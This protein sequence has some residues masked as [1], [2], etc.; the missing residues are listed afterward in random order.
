MKAVRRRVRTTLIGSLPLLLLAACGTH[1][2]P[3]SEEAK[4]SVRAELATAERVEIPRRVEVH[5]IVEAEKTA[6]ISSRVS[7]MITRVLVKPGDA[8]SRGQVLIRID[9]QTADGQLAQA[10]GAL[11]QAQAA[12][13]LAERNFERFT[14]LAATDAASELEVDQARMQHEQALGAVEQA[15]GAIQ[16][17]QSVAAESRV[18]APFSGRIVRKM[19][20]VGDLAAPG[21]P[22]L[23]LESEGPRLLVLSVPESLMN[24]AAL[25]IGDL[26]PIRF[27]ARP[28]LGL[29]EAEVVEMTPAAD[30]VSHSFDIKLSLSDVDIAS[31]SSGRGWIPTAVREAVLA[32]TRALLQVGG[33]TLVVAKTTED[34]TSSRVVTLGESVDDERIEVLS[35]LA[36]GEVLLL[37]LK[38]VPPNGSPVEEGS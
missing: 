27:D 23:L 12:L 18:T 19:V 5:G 34:V 28:E 32:P 35:G 38:A 37:D 15:R 3:A 20:D 24:E 26:L 16:A 8:V 10:R 9:P 25:A 1:T 6:A 11:A 2:T 22:L 7:A 14:A 36:G 21:R 4:P 33:M 13:A 17:A 31:G 29:L 30:P